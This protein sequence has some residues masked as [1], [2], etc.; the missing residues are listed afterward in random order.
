MKIMYHIT[1]I[2]NV[3][4]ILNEGLK[5]NDEGDVFL[6]E[7]CDV[8]LQW[9]DKYIPIDELIATNQLFL[10]NYVMFEVDVTGLALLNDNVA[11]S[12]AKWQY[13]YKGDIPKGRIKN[14]QH[15]TNATYT[16]AIDDIK[17]QYK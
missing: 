9:L 13:I 17:K 4:S 7:G 1:K 3:D 2:E 10:Q 16:K 5:K 14:Y 12:T 8:Y 11:E 6:F 15:R